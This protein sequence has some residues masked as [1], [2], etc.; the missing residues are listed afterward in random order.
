MTAKQRSTCYPIWISGTLTL[1]LGSVVLFGWIFNMVW[2]TRIYFQWNPM[3][4]ST[5]FCFMLAGLS[6]L[7]CKISPDEKIPNKFSVAQSILI[8][9][10]LLLAGIRIFELVSAHEFGIE[11]LLP[12]LGMKFDI[13]GHMSP[14]T[15]SGFLA[16]GMGMLAI[17]HDNKRKYRI[18][19]GILAGVL[20]LTGL[21]GIVGYWLDF[22]Y[23][24][25]AMYIKTGL[26]W[27]AFHTAFGMVLLGSG[28][29]YLA[30]RG[31]IGFDTNSVEEQAAT[32]YRTTVLVL[33][34]TALTT[35]LAGIS[36]L[37]QS[38]YRQA[39]VDLEHSL[40]AIR[41]HIDTSLDNRIQRALLA[42]L[43]PALQADVSS[44]LRKPERKMYGTQHSRYIN[45]LLKHGFSGIAIDD[46]KQ[47]KIFAGQLI[48]DTIHSVRLNG[49]TTA[50]L[51]WDN[52]YYLRVRIPLSGKSGRFLLLEQTLPRIDK[53]LE[54]TNHWGGLARYQCVHV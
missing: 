45:D 9:L 51:A 14:Q 52:K 36:F 30:M 46:G 17:R 34:V 2:L 19:A 5:A 42:G 1:L 25:E 8:W 24:F 26:I 38:L 13:V 12:V 27:M 15:A 50:S 22:H 4:P 29:L 11:F 10:V 40:D 33:F 23:I 16:F 6:L 31:K 48:H 53:V 37:D 18:F 44:L 43:D 39:S 28:L 7:T 49:E 32:I 3:V 35:G 54:D 20:L 47:R 41:L 21:L